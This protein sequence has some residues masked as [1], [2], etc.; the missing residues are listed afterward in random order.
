MNR[1]WDYGCN[2][3]YEVFYKYN[4]EYLHNNSYFI[5]ICSIE[6]YRQYEE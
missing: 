4:K 2:V 5:L 6:L 1:K 3:K